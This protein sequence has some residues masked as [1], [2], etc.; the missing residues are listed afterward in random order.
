M[1]LY[2]I[3]TFFSEGFI[4]SAGSDRNER[5]KTIQSII[6]NLDLY[7]FL[8]PLL[9]HFRIL[10]PGSLPN[11]KYLRLNNTRL[12]KELR[13]LIKAYNEIYKIIWGIKDSKSESSIDTQRSYSPGL[14]T[15]KNF[16]DEFED[17]DLHEKAKKLPAHE[18]KLL[19]AQP[20]IN[21]FHLKLVCECPNSQEL[22]EIFSQQ[23]N[24]SGITPMVSFRNKLSEISA[25]DDTFEMG[26]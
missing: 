1:V 20:D 25:P 11:E 12:Q 26:M 5:L 2:L 23:P 14:F 6:N 7:N 24:D 3:T 16:S 19:N 9:H 8:N 15:H 10:K 17:Y 18:I 4:F 22:F 21:E 13:K